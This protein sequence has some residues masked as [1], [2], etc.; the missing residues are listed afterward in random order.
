MVTPMQ[1]PSH[2]LWM[3][4]IDKVTAVLHF[5]DESIAWGVAPL[6]KPA[7][8]DDFD[9]FQQ[10]NEYWARLNNPTKERI[11]QC[12][13][14]M[15]NILVVRYDSKQLSAMLHPY[16]NELV[17]LMDLNALTYW[18]KFHAKTITIPSSFRSEY[19]TRST[20][21]FDPSDQ[22]EDTTPVQ[23]GT[24]EKTYLREDAI[25][26]LALAVVARALCPIF[27]E[28]ITLT[29]SEVGNNFKELNTG[30]LVAGTAFE[31]SPA[32]EKLR[33]YVSENIQTDGLRIGPALDGISSENYPNWVLYLVLVRRLTIVD[34]RGINPKMTIVSSVHNY[35]T[36]RS[37]NADSNF[38]FGPVSDKKLPEGKGDE[39]S[40]ISA[41]ENNS[42]KDEFSPGDL[43]EFLHYGRDTDAIINVLCPQLDRRLVAEAQDAAKILLSQRIHDQQITIMQWCIGPYMAPAAVMELNRL[44]VVNL[45]AVVQ[46]IL[47][48]TGFRDIAAFL[49]TTE[50]P[51]SEVRRIS[52]HMNR[53][54]I[55]RSLIDEL[56]R[57][58]PHFLRPSGSASNQAKNATQTAV[59]RKMVSSMLEHD[60]QLNVP[61]RWRQELEKTSTYQNVRINEYR[62]PA[63]IRIS[64]AT[65]ALRIGRFPFPF[66]PEHPVLTH[67]A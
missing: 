22:E 52:T 2:S 1:E 6:T 3:E 33:L 29:S 25:G 20:K 4:L 37:T 45:L 27:A 61:V 53:S 64:L 16:I 41:L 44:E 58:F 54:N 11:F 48:Q 32:Y 57:T 10:L 14:E 24:R 42:I 28:Y 19:S 9:L 62:I 43:V 46:A 18:V 59:V 36:Y 63:D 39:E 15:R 66:H 65:L 35:I 30:M 7:L 31:R 17:E 38:S 51:K 21:Q 8:K 50:M 60:W 67:S 49:T 56:D 23:A 34:I 47:W 13:R 40:K 12:Y 26:L 55:P 5:N